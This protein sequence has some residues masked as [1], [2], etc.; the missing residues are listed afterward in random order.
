MKRLRHFNW[1][2]FLSMML[3]IGIGTAAIWSAGSARSETLFHG[4]WINNLT[5]AAFGLVIYFV[6]AF[7][8]RIS[9]LIIQTNRV[10]PH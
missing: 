4:M 5:T 3:L 1:I 9:Y 7:L 6:L 2:M 8:K 10:E